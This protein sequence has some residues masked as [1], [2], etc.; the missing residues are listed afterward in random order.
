MMK[1]LKTFLLLNIIVVLAMGMTVSAAGSGKLV[2]TADKTELQPG[3]TVTITLNV[4]EN[5]GIITLDGVSVKYDADVFSVIAKTPDPDVEGSEE[6][7]LLPD[8]ATRP[9]TDDQNDAG[10]V[11]YSLGK[12]TARSNYTK[13]GAVATLV[14]NVKDSAMNGTTDVTVSLTSSLDKDEEFVTFSMSPVALTIT[15][16]KC[17]HELSKVSAVA[18][19]CEKEGNKEYYKCS[20]CGK[21]FSDAAGTTETTGD[22][23]VIKAIGHAW[24]NGT[25]TKAATCTEKGVKTYTCTHDSSHTMTEDIAATGHNWDEGKVTTEPGCE[26]KGVKTYTCTNDSSHTKTEAISATGHSWDE[27]KVT[28]EP[29]CE[30]KGV[31]TYTCKNDSSHTQTEDI[32][33]T[34][35]SW[36]PGK[37]TTEPGC[38]TKGVKTYTCTHDSSHTMTEDI[39]ATGH[40]WDEG[41]VTKTA[42]ATEDGII[43]YTCTKDSSHTKAETFKEKTREPEVNTVTSFS[44]STVTTKLIN[45]LV[46]N[47]EYT[48][49]DIAYYDI[50]MKVSLDNG[51]TYVPVTAETMPKEGVKVRIPYPSGTNPVDYDF[52]VLHLLSN[53]TVETL[54]PEEASEYLIITAK[55]FSPF[56]V[57]YK[58]GEEDEPDD[59]DDNASTATTAAS[60]NST[61]TANDGTIRSPKTGDMISAAMWIL[62]ACACATILLGTAYGYKNKR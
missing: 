8:I 5:P 32:P 13:T 26:T 54:E 22:A 38:E 40:S 33:A 49:K 35:H 45:A 58:E 42:T 60:S 53:G 62:I 25:V 3:D 50:E 37:V 31:K 14:L 29:G 19:T 18:A 56:A 1:K 43:T 2:L 24:D 17:V 4:T 6:G 41:V 9:V 39:A 11:K 55:S 20:I 59:G 23:V 12:D 34:G 52:V 16:G 10:T 51:K 27:G 48:E 21:L 30:T 15:G 61:G 46:S 47:K 36:D 57:G 44:D 7:L 28:T